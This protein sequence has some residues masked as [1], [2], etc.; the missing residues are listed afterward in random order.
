MPPEELATIRQKAADWHVVKEVRQLLHVDRDLT[1]LTDDLEVSKPSR[2]QQ[3]PITHDPL[4]M[5]HYQ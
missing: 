2:R 3:S 1:D 4:P 5:T